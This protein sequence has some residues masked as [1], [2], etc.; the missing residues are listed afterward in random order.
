MKFY[1]CR[2]CGNIITKVDDSGV[3]VVCCGD[4]MEELVANTAEASLEKHIPVL[5]ETSEGFTIKVGSIEHPMTE[6]H[7]IAWIAYTL[8]KELRIIHLDINTKP[9][10]FVHGK[11][12]KEVYAYCNLHGLWKAEL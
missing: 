6:E 1:I 11:F 9:E 10:I 4:E 7:H 5:E 12:I 2:H 3:N 8:D